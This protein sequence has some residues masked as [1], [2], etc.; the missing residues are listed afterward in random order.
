MDSLWH[1]LGRSRPKEAGADGRSP[2]LDGLR[3]IAI[4]AVVLHHS[5]IRPAHFLDWGPFGVRLFFVMSAFLITR[6]L[7]K[8]GGSERYL[9]EL[10]K[11]HVRRFARLLPAYLAALLF[12]LLAGMEEVRASLLWHLGFLSNFHLAHLGWFPAATGHFWSLAVQEQFYIVWPFVLLAVP[13]RKFPWAAGAL[14]A[15]GY[16]FR[17][18]CLEVDVPEFWRWFMLPGCVDTFA[19][20]GLLAWCV[21][22]YGLPDP[23]VGGLRSASAAALVAVLWICNRL[24]RFYPGSP[25]LE[26]L[27]DTLEA[28]VAAF[29][30]LIAVAGVRGPVGWILELRVLVSLGGISYGVF[31]YHLIIL[32]LMEPWLAQFGISRQTQPLA[33]AALILAVTV[34]VALLSWRV[35]E[36]PVMKAMKRKMS[37]DGHGGALGEK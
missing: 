18:W 36:Q 11:F 23:G 1:R 22:R 21:N 37:V 25:W 27:P 10:K 26:A 19:A 12:G 7:W 3:G 24:I 34:P 13:F 29:L 16:G 31:V 2:Q 6:S 8:L 28:V 4:L 9:Q 20:G 30:V 15:S 35:L 5:G 32:H 14:V 33:V 17:V